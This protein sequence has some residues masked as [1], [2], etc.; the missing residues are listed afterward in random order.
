MDSLQDV[1]GRF[2]QK[3][4]TTTEII[5]V[6]GEKETGLRLKQFSDEVACLPN[7]WVRSGI[8][9]AS[10]KLHYEINP[11]TNQKQRLTYH[12]EQVPTWSENVKIWYTGE[13]LNLFDLHV[14]MTCVT[15]CKYVFLG[16]TI[17]LSAYD[18]CE[19]AKIKRGGNTVKLIKAS[20]QRIFRASLESKLYKNGVL[21]REYNDHMIEFF[22]IDEKTDQWEIGLN[23]KFF[24]MFQYQTTWIDWDKWTAFRSDIT[25]ALMMQICSHE[26]SHHKPQKISL[27]KLKELMRNDQP[28]FTFRKLIKTHLPKLIEAEVLKNYIL[29]DDLITFIRS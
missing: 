7:E 17:K 4:Q 6:P 8:F 25:K 21:L 11:R 27:L 20:L 3:G 16:K 1:I 5:D 26:A 10:N 9:T 18:F 2:R 15:L 19:I 29:K 22:Y 24:P 12:R 23:R 14:W 13:E 28:M